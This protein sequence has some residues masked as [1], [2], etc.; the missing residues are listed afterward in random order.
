MVN[1]KDETVT[2]PTG[3]TNNPPAPALQQL[4]PGQQ[5]I[6]QQPIVRYEP[7]IDL[8][9][10]TGTQ[11]EGWLDAVD[12]I[13]DT[14]DC[15]E[16]ARF[17]A[18][19]SRIPIEVQQSLDPDYRTKATFKEKY[20][21]FKD[22]IKSRYTA[23]QASR[24]NELLSKCVLGNKKPSHLLQ[25]MR[26]KAKDHATPSMLESLWTQRLPL[27]VQTAVAAAVSST[28]DEKA[29][30]ADAVVEATGGTSKPPSIAAIDSGGTS[31]G[32][33]LYTSQGPTTNS[34][35]ALLL[36][37]KALREEVAELRLS[38]GTNSNS[39]GA[40]NR[41][42]RSRSRSRS[43]VATSIK[44]GNNDNNNDD[45]ADDRR[46]NKS[47]CWYHRTFGDKAEHCIQDFC[48]WNSTGNGSSR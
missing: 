3:S 37:I 45:Q 47:L 46:R 18:L 33:A 39:Q 25:E 27:H 13:F 7:K 31:N 6:P 4:Q 43:R 32:A 15:D 34:E 38:R 14:H 30:I 21:T 2:T 44:G 40:S 41:R 35:T 19:L 11:V 26:N 23:S 12:M 9:Q 48:K 36:Q 24:I 42:G 1:P 8:P 5:Q 17:R 28:I 16:K 20:D 10:W 29:K 22:A